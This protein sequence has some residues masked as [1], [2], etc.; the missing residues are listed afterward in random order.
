VSAIDCQKVCFGYT[1][2][3]QILDGVSFQVSAG[4]ICGLVGASGSG[5][6][7]LLRLLAGLL[8]GSGHRLEGTILLDGRAPTVA[9]RAGRL[10]FVFQDMKLLPFLSV[11]DNL[12]WTSK[13]IRLAGRPVAADIDDLLHLV[14]LVAQT[15][16]WPKELS[17]GMKAR[18]AIA[19][20][21]LTKPEVLLLDEALS[22]LDIGWRLHLHREL[23][24][25]RDRL[26]I[27]IFM[28]SHDLE[29][30]TRLADHVLV[31]S[32]SGRVAGI[33]PRSAADADRLATMEQLILADH[34]AQGLSQ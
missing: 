1:T 6:S 16:A 18:L 20:A 10:G 17:G 33:L 9:R 7:T 25:L 19:R 29:E 24:A 5:K 21:L 3:R 8:P 13:Q 14:G 12:I 28:I 2:D 26:G 32:S 11:R 31:L 30:I 27:T 15:S 23:A 4:E 22:S 34:P